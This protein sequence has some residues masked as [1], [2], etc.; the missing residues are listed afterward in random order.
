MTT[1]Y[2][3]FCPHNFRSADYLILMAFYRIFRKWNNSEVEKP[4]DY[5]FF[6]VENFGRIMYCNK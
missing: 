3:W 5:E 6:N 2:F 1:K 4:F